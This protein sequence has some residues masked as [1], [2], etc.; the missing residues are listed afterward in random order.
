MNPITTPQKVLDFFYHINQIPRGSHNEKGISDYLVDFAKDRALEVHQDSAYNV[1]IKKPA[2]P[3]YEDYPTVILQGH[4]D[5]VCMKSAASNH[6][7]ETDPIE[8]IVDGDWLHANETTLGAD[9]GIAVAMSLAVLDSNDIAHGP[10]EAL[11]T[12]AEEVGMD[13]AIAI[14]GS[15]LS[16][17]YLLNMDTEKENEFIVSCAGGSRLTIDVPLL[18]EPRDKVY[19]QGL[20][21]TLHGLH[22][23]HS[24]LEIHK[25]Y[26]NANQ[27]MARTLYE[28]AQRFHFSMAHFAGG[29]KHNAIP[30]F[31]EALLAVREEDVDSICAYIK[32]KQHL[33]QIEFAPQET[34]LTITTESVNAPEYVYAR[35]TT[36]G[37]LSFLYLAPHGVFGMS[38]SLPNLVETSNNLAVVTE[39]SRSVRILVSMR[40]SQS[41]ALHYLSG[42]MTLLASKLGLKVE[43]DGQYPAWEYEPG[44]ALEKQA[45]SVYEKVFGQAPHVT[46]VHAGLECGILKE[47]LPNTEMISFGPN[48]L[49]AHTPME[50]VSISSVGKIYNFLLEL[51]KTLK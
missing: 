22:G 5:M 21:V 4:I 11:F 18:R 50:K 19:T 46:A 24:G 16:G 30:S 43:L 10:I 42:K 38:Q 7:F 34:N 25:Q 33:Y 2:T 1:I 29:T 17:T 20:A 49:F 37:L 51:L 8:L 27:L 36:E 12:A 6:N 14:D 45:V 15:L 13:G 9:N 23:G 26:A 35:A 31:A 48:I 41:N 47:H 39:A 3:G 40:S 32:E 44:S 28:L